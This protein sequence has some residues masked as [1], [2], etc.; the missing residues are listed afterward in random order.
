MTDTPNPKRSVYKSAEVCEIARLQPYVL[1]TWEAEF[2]NLGVTR[3]S[4]GRVYRQVDL[5]RVLRIKRM[6]VD[7][8]LTL[9]G[10]RRR[11]ESEEAPQPE[12]PLEELLASGIKERI[13]RVR[14]ELQEVF[15]LLTRG[16]ATQPASE[17]P[18]AWPAAADAA[19]PL[20]D[21][22]VP[23]EGP[24]LSDQQAAPPQPAA[25]DD[26]APGSEI[27]AEASPTPE[28]ANDAE[29]PAARATRR[30]RARRSASRPDLGSPS[31]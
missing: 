11:L 23:T 7:E 1:R 8:G 26:P 25:T 16:S 5:D 2:P 12:L 30:P 10:V 18:A 14:E 9:A 6:V 13:K 28:Q 3:P 4:G 17:R 21:P 24:Q 19:P 15:A 31:Q 29:G 22:S 20:P 27:T